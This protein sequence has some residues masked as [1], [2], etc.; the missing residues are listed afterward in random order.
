MIIEKNN[1]GIYVA[2]IQTEHGKR[3]VKLHVT[4]AAQARQ[5]ARD[6]K[7]LEAELLSKIGRV[8]KQ[9]IAH[10]VLGRELSVQQAV[11]EW[12]AF[13]KSRRSPKSVVNNSL[14][15]HAWMRD[16][17]VTDIHVSDITTKHVD[18]WINADSN[19]AKLSTL[20]IWLSTFN[21]FFEFCLVRNYC[22]GNPAAE[23]R[24]KVEQ[25][26]M[27]R[28]E[29][30]KTSPFSEGDYDVILRAYGSQRAQVERELKEAQR[31]LEAA[32]LGHNFT[33]FLEAAIG[34]H[35]EA[36]AENLFWFCAVQVAWETG[37]RLGDICQLEWAS[38]DEPGRL[39]VWTEKTNTR[40][41]LRIRPGLHALIR[42]VPRTRTKD[43]FVFPEQRNLYV[44]VNKRYW[45]SQ[46][47]GR[48]L[49]RAGIHGHSFHD[50]RRSN[51]TLANRH[52]MPVELIRE[53]LGHSSSTT[54]KGYI[55]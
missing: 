9:V 31:H 16:Q 46:R 17:K 42:T 40:I 20:K 6:S 23:L 37:L 24:I 25:L 26:S 18:S 47:F 39:V 12:M 45:F 50:F 52:G 28:K 48:F 43:L 54:T 4:N 51:A 19:T 55:K 38:F 11:D 13:L 8:K 7:L 21:R 35:R 5:V 41:C 3:T 49:V 15:I 32:I 22:I 33:G 1:A 29:T 10:V 34:R 36:L 2:R 53:R 27:S 14:V 30:R 44:D